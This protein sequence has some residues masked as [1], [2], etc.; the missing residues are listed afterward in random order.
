M[1]LYDDDISDI[2]WYIHHYASMCLIYIFRCVWFNRYL[3]RCYNV[4]PIVTFSLTLD[5]PWPS[6][7]I[8]ALTKLNE[9]FAELGLPSISIRI[10]LHTGDSRHHHY[11]S[12]VI[13]CHCVF[14]QREP[15][16]ASR[17]PDKQPYSGCDCKQ[18]GSGQGM[19]VS[20]FSPTSDEP[21]F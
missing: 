21:V 2:W 5:T 6:R 4:W 7:S 20:A 17:C 18:R 15:L 12:L 8:Q 9:S 16:W 11:S 10:G 1:I 3:P 13:W 19:F 14:A